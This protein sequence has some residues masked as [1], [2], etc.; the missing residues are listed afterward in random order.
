MRTEG[1]LRQTLALLAE[2]APLPQA[3]LD[4]LTER[5]GGAGG[6]PRSSRR[7]AVVRVAAV[8]V[9]LALLLPTVVTDWTAEPAGLRVR[10][11]WNL[12]HRVEPASGSSA[13]DQ[14]V[15]VYSELSTV[16][17]TDA[18][19]GNCTVD[20]HGPQAPFHPQR[21]PRR[22]AGHH[23]RTRRVLPRPAAV[24]SPVVRRTQAESARL[25]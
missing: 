11:N 19:S 21:Q 23:R 13:R 18:D 5:S 4:R 24:R 17:S 15:L 14:V 10:G 1:Q 6:A 7:V 9:I 16:D 25:L 2:Q 3:V 22:R 8:V 12:V 20:V